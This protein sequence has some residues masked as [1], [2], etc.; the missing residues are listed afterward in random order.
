MATARS[1]QYAYSVDDSSDAPEEAKGLIKEVD[2]ELKD[3]YKD[4]DIKI[5]EAETKFNA[6]IAR[7]RTLPQIINEDRDEQASDDEP[8]AASPAPTPA[9]E[10]TGTPTATAQPTGGSGSAPVALAPTATP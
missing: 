1:I 10:S 7:F 2:R 6:M 5:P 3:I 4:E 9:P 8:A